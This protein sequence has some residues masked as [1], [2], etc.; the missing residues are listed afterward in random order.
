[1]V[2]RAAPECRYVVIDEEGRV[3]LAGRAP[4]AA[5]ASFHLDL[6]GMLPAGRFTLS[7]QLI[8]NGN[9]M[10]AEIGNFPIEVLQQ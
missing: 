2:K 4:V 10:N 5:D 3:V 8:V 7:A 1:V 9:A 6:G